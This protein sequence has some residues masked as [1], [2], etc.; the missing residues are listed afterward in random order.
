LERLPHYSC[1]E[2][3]P[4]AELRAELLCRIDDGIDLATEARLRSGQRR[5]DV[6]KRNFSDDEQIHVARGSE[7]PA[8]GRAVDQG[9]TN[10]V[11]QRS[12]G[13]AK[14]VQQSGGLQEDTLELLENRRLRI[15]LVEDVIASD[16]APKDSR[17]GQLLELLRDGAGGR[18]A[19]PNQLAHVKRLIR[20]SEEP[21]Q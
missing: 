6:A 3:V 12:Q 10:S 15:R 18:A 21:A 1:Q 13:S 20:M 2:V 4:G 8:R 19:D 9:D 11:R 17:R 14:L 7:R 16:G 5:D